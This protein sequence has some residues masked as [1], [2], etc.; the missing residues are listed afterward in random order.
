MIN[1]RLYPCTKVF[2]S[3]VTVSRTAL[4]MYRDVLTDFVIWRIWNST[5]A[6]PGPARRARVPRLKKKGLVFVNF[7]CIYANTLILVNM[8]CLQYVYYSLLF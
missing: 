7:H 4:Y 1:I 5:K 3:K 2:T 8:S 6:D